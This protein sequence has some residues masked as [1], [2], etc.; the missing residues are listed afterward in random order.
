ML[1]A[2]PAAPMLGHLPY[3]FTVLFGVMT[4]AGVVLV[5]VDSRKEQKHR[6]L[7]PKGRS[8][9]MVFM[10]AATAAGAWMS[11]DAHSAYQEIDRYEAVLARSV[12]LLAHPDVFP[13]KILAAASS[14]EPSLQAAAAKHPNAP[15]EALLGLAQHGPLE[16]KMIVAGR[17]DTPTEALLSLSRHNDPE[18]S[19]AAI[20]NPAFPS[21]IVNNDLTSSLAVVG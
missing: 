3:V 4:I 19:G 6:E 20:R 17:A 11:V 5:I 2:R 18:I 21:E 12:V 13:E 7:G 1:A 10:V 8:A 14:D 16:A 9:L 15:A